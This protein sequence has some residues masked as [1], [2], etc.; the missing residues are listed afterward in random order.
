MAAAVGDCG[1]IAQMS[2]NIMDSG[3]DGLTVGKR[4]HKYRKGESRMDPVI[5]D[6]N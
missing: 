3:S 2:K 5:L 4:Y 6:W 1:G